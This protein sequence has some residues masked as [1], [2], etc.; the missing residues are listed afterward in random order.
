[1]FLVTI[2][3]VQDFIAAAR[4][5]RDLRA[6]S[7]LLSDL[8]REAAEFIR[9][10]DARA[11]LIFPSQEHLANH[12]VVNR[13]LAVVFVPPEDIGPR[14]EFHLR[15][16]LRE[17]ADKTFAK[18]KSLHEVGTS[19]S[20]KDQ[21]DELMEIFWAGVTFT[22]DYHSDRDN[23]EAA[24]AA[25]KNTRDFFQPAYRDMVPKSS[26]DGTRESVIPE[27][28]FPSRNDHN[29]IR[30]QKITQLFVLFGAGQAERLS[31]VDLFKRHYRA[32]EG[33]AD[34][35]STSHFAALPLLNRLSAQG[36]NYAAALQ[37]YVEALAKLAAPTE[38]LNTPRFDYLALT[39]GYDA[40]LLFEERLSDVVEE[41]ELKEARGALAD[42]FAAATRGERPEPYYAIL[43]ADGDNMGKVIDYQAK[44]KSDQQA[45]DGIVRHKAFSQALDSFAEAV[46]KIVESEQYRGALVYAGG[47][48]VLAFLPLD[49]AVACAKHLADSFADALKDYKGEHGEAATLS[50]GLAVC[51]HIEPLSDALNLARAA[52]KIAKKAKAKNSLA[53]TLSKRSGADI[54]VAGSWQGDF[55]ER[56]NRFVQLHQVDALPD[57]AAFELRDLDDRVGLTLAPEALIA[58]ALRILER[59]R[60]QHGQAKIE[61]A[62]LTMIKNALDIGKA[63]RRAAD[64]RSVWG[65]NELADELIV[66]RVFAR[67]QGPSPRKEP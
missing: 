62:D 18:I 25:R 5:T 47:D 16:M 4:R 48:D 11:D 42:F 3:P 39:G 60:A 12:D 44:P 22:D 33:Y 15:E 7:Q 43:H 63:E 57:G 27:E 1:M 61:P 54:T 8:S 45:I 23:V 29:S 38:K 51:H 17:Q 20:A 34:F 21:V 46:R 64:G 10:M 52:E 30:R 32:S 24:L 66:A 41:S 67:A 53:I 49:T 40:S 56:L 9:T 31:G 50:V 26:I 28:Y 14:L 55:Y 37:L 13:I 6:G 36:L 35:P 65:V 58:D 59:K 2:G 19:N